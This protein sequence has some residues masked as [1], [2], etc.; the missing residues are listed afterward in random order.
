[1]STVRSRRDSRDSAMQRHETDILATA[2]VPAPVGAR[3]ERDESLGPEQACRYLGCADASSHISS[4]RGF[5]SPSG[6]VPPGRFASPSRRLT[7]S[8][9]SRWTGRRHAVPSRAVPRPGGSSP[10][11]PRDG[12]AW[13]TTSRR[14]CAPRGWTPGRGTVRRLTGGPWTGRRRAAVGRAVKR[15]QRCCRRGSF[16]LSMR[17]GWCCWAPWG[18]HALGP[19]HAPAGRRMCP[20]RRDHRPGAC[21]SRDRGGGRR[22]VRRFRPHRHPRPPWCEHH[23]PGRGDPGARHHQQHGG[24]RPAVEHRP[25]RGPG[26]GRWANA[27][28]LQQLVRQADGRGSRPLA[29]PRPGAAAVVAIVAVPDEAPVPC[30]WALPPA[31]GSAVGTVPSGTRSRPGTF[32]CPCGSGRRTPFLRRSPDRKPP[33]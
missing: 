18:G 25:S 13:S 33:G 9:R 27:P 14:R 6:V 31:S 26:R 3:S 5:L 30:G 1:M 7:P 21:G 8:L 12:P 17:N 4:K 32:S 29:R 28:R 22:R 23:H 19:R 11:P 24:G 15:S 20:G 10:G 16:G 2:A